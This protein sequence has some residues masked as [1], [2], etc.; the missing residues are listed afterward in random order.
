MGWRMSG[1]K[2]AGDRSCQEKERIG[3]RKC[4]TIFAA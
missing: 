2:P 3:R 1:R 4:V